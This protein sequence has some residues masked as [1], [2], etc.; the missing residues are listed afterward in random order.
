MLNTRTV[1]CAYV[2]HVEAG[3][4]EMIAEWG[5]LRWGFFG[6]VTSSSQSA[7]TCGLWASLVCSMLTDIAVVLILL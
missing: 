4:L 2:I 1:I 6:T 7:R 5:I 3:Q